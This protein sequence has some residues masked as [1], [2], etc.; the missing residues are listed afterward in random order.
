ML[1]SGIL[2]FAIGM[3]FMFL[4]VSLAAG[5]ATEALAAAI[6]WRART[7]VQ[8]IKTLLNDKD[9]KL[10]AREIYQHGLI[11][12]RGEGTKPGE[13]DRKNPSYIQ[14]DQFAAALFEILNSKPGVTPTAP[15]ADRTESQIYQ[16]KA[17]VANKLNNGNP[18][19]KQML[20]GIIDRAQGEEEK[21]RA[22]LSKWFDNGMD[23]ISGF[24]K[25][26]S[27]LVSFGFALAIA[28]AL[29][30]SAIDVA[31]S[32]WSHPVDTTV[33]AGI[34]QNDL[35][36]VIN[37]L[38]KLHETTALPTGWPRSDR[39]TW[40]TLIFGWSITGFAGLFGAP[41]WFDLLQQIIR[42]KGSGPSPSEK[43]EKKGAAA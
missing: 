25:R 18:Q 22:E 30:L 9:F 11:N 31:T 12:P 24:Y 5:A 15:P 10:L 40:L 27:Q 26:W 4:T 36:G 35:Q 6:N 39:S 16:L 1:G 21:I 28:I 13:K 14:P 3:I 19:I 32:L 7:L 29:N 8:G 20:D 38:N 34:K 23:R 37:E 41:F 43:E 17:N 33:L 2:D 42:L